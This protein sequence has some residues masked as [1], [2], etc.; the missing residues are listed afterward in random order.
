M[1]PR[2][3]LRREDDL[4]DGVAVQYLLESVPGLIERERSVDGGPFER[5]GDLVSLPAFS[6]K[7]VQHGK[8]Y[9]YE[10]SAI[11]VRDNESARSSPAEVTF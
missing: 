2:P 10:V 1:R 5:I 4:A 8:S 7:D 9:S 6:D 11:D 3:R